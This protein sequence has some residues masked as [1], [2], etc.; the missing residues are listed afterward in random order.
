MIP[1]EKTEAVA[2]A[3]QDA[4]GVTRFED[5]R[6]LSNGFSGA[7]VY[8]IVVGGS[9]F[10]LRLINHTS[11]STVRDHFACMNAAAEAGLAPR[12]RYT[13]AE[14]Q[15]C[16]TDFVE[17]V[18]FPLDEAAARMPAL[19]RMLHALPPF[20]TRAGHLNTS[21]MFL[22]NGGTA[23]DGFLQRFQKA[24]ILPQTVSEQ[25][26]AWHTLL[27]AAYSRIAPDMVSS[28]NDLLKPDN[29]L[30]DGQRVWLIDWEAAFLN[31]RYADLAVMAD[32]LAADHAEVSVYLEKYF[33]Q[34]PDAFQMARF[35]T[36]RQVAHMFYAMVFLLLGAGG[37]QVNLSGNVPDFAD[38]HRRVWAGEFSLHDNPTKIL[39][40]R[41]HLNRLF[42]DMQEP[43]VQESLKIASSAETEPGA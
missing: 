23:L 30:F 9:A 6:K 25:L 29:I 18:P 40:G 39:Y 43:H 32:F 17:S 15:I 36:A 26:F 11:G 10:L 16:I 42:H 27:T 33:G 24:N 5:I 38:F 7:L 21:C 8:R 20:P 37:E 28:H 4:F 31:D 35:V 12:V 1:Q 34:K 14:S 41:V 19:L 13:S 3:L 22:I 2:R